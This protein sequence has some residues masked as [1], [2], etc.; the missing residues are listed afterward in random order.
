MYHHSQL[1][2]LKMKKVYLFHITMVALLIGGFIINN[3]DE[4][5]DIGVINNI[6]LSLISFSYLIAILFGNSKK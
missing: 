4:L 3:I 1:N 5:S 6:A 2:Y